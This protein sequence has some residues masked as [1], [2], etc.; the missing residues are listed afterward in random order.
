MPLS[1]EECVAAIERHSAGFAEATR[2]NLSAPVE[3]C[4]GWS[5][6]DLVWHLTEV[7]WFWATIAEERSAS[8]PD[9]SRCPP[10]ADDAGLVGVFEAGAGRLADVLRAA[11]QSAA[12]W[13]WAAQRDVAFVTRHQVQEAA[14]HHWDAVH[15]AGGALPIEPAVAADSVDE[16]LTFSVSSDADHE[17]PPGEPLAGTFVVRAADTGDAWTLTDGDLPGTV[18]VSAGATAAPTLEAAAGDLLLWLYGRVDLDTSAV[19]ADLLSRF[20]ALCFTD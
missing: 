20:R 2:E 6:A 18:R 19:P 16:F 5:V 14:V 10:R 13:T 1:T 17:D 4:P 12:C 8:P 15:A 11:D 9:E 3:H 7:H